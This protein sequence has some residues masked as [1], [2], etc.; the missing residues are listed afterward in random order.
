MLRKKIR[1]DTKLLFSASI[2]LTSCRRA[3][4][5]LRYIDINEPLIWWPSS[6]LKQSLR[7]LFLPNL[8]ITVNF[9]SQNNFISIQ[10]RE[11][12][13][14]LC[15]QTLFNSAKNFLKLLNKVTFRNDHYSKVCFL[16]D[17]NMQV[18]R[19][20]YTM[21]YLLGLALGKWI[22]SHHCKSIISVFQ[23]SMICPASSLLHFYPLAF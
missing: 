20:S 2:L 8:N 22:V 12:G 9:P 16:S 1:N 21:K 14:F 15:F 3:P 6:S 4:V 5:P 17:E 19:H 13:L 10:R 23:S 7:A 18:T 11:H